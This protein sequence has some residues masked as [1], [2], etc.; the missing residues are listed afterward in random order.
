MLK[1]IRKIFVLFIISVFVVCAQDKKTIDIKGTILA[2]SDDKALGISKGDPIIGATIIVDG[3][4]KGVTADLDGNFELKEVPVG[5]VLKISF[6]G[7]KT[8]DVPIDGSTSTFNVEMKT[9]SVVLD[10]VVAVGYGE[11]KR[12]QVTGSNV[13]VGAKDIGRTINTNI[14]EG[15]AGRAAG[16]AVTGTSGAPGAATSVNIRGIGSLNGSQ[17]LYVIDGVP[18]DILNGNIQNFN[19]AD[20]ESMEVLKDAAAT[21]IF[22]SRGANGVV[23]IT[24][25]RGKK[26]AGKIDFDAMYGVQNVWK[27]MDMLSPEAYKQYMQDV[28]KSGNVPVPIAYTTQ[29]PSILSL[30]A[31]TNWQNE[32]FRT[33][34]IQ[35]YNI[36][37]SG[38]SDFA[39]YSIGLGY[40]RNDGTLKKSDYD[41][42]TLRINSDITPKKWLK[43]GESL[44]FSKETN[45]EGI[46]WGTFS[47]WGLKGNPLIPVYNTFITGD[48]SIPVK[49]TPTIHDPSKPDEI[50]PNAFGYSSAQYQGIFGVN[51]LINP[52]AANTFTNNRREK[53]RIFGNIYAEVELGQ[54]LGLNALKGLKARA[55][56]GADVLTGFDKNVRDIFNAGSRLNDNDAVTRTTVSNDRYTL[57]SSTTDYTLSY[58]KLVGDHDLSAVAGFSAQYF[59]QNNLNAQAKDFPTGLTEFSSNINNDRRTQYN[60]G[61]SKNENGLVG[62]LAR[63]NYAYKNTY[64]ITANARYDASSRFGPNFRGG[65]FPSASVGWRLNNT[66]LKD[67]KT[68]SDLKLRVG[69]GASGNQEIGNYLYNQFIFTGIIRYPL[70]DGVIQ[71]GNAPTKGLAN[72]NLRWETVVQYN[73]GLDLGLLKN[74]ILF[75]FDVYQ[76]ESSGML[77]GVPLPA[78]SGATNVP[79]GGQPIAFTNIGRITN[80]G[81][82][83]A[84]TY[85]NDNGNFKYAISPNVSF[86]RN[87]VNSLSTSSPRESL[88]DGNGVSYSTPSFSAAYFNGYVYDGVIMTDADSAN[89]AGNSAYKAPNADT[90]IIN[91]IAQ[92]YK[93]K[94]DAKFKDLDGDG[95]ITANDRTKIGSPIPTMTFGFSFDATFKN[96]DFKLFLQ[97]ITGNSIYNSQRSDLEGMKNEGGPKDANQLASVENRWTASNPSSAMPR[98]LLADNRQNTRISSRWIED[99]SYMR[100][101]NIQLGYSLPSKLLQKLMRTEDGVSL[102]FYI[103]VQNLLTI[104]AYKGFD[105]ELANFSRNTAGEQIISAS[106]AGYDNGQFPQPRTFS[107]GLQFSF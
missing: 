88:I 22:G 84:L 24:T 97:G 2:G 68:I 76:K 67:V 28:Y 1:T 61:G 10:E 92:K 8:V 23:L 93:Q 71:T 82:E 17:P 15:L 47:T 105:P 60:I 34:N 4:T 100:I 74:K 102:R 56:F 103:Q 25:K 89:Y 3:T 87:T 6:Q 32:M 40:F 101:K 86:L 7:L 20:V 18:L 52:V 107:A 21:A 106:V 41:R 94:G 13:S 26:G 37:A 90:L 75:T 9:N 63:V 48:S 58:T 91:D 66:F 96:F 55:S 53:Y 11:I 42:Y 73:L 5:S 99:G 16:V 49:L 19:T 36:R 14:A 39:T 80:Q 104:T 69:I 54:F 79:L 30:Q 50:Q 64:M 85:R 27:K 59:Q 57:F 98:A 51:D 44:S 62:V 31:N 45:N 35:N 70:A 46:D 83:L 38:G 65:F 78:L 29:D 81:I 77:I 95:R 33:G 43:I 12:S 72:P